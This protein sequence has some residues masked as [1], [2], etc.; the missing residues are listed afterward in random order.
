[1]KIWDAIVVGAGPAGCAAAYDLAVRGREVL[2][3]D[4]ADFPRQKACAGGL[5]IKAV[6]ALRYS[7]EPVVRQKI[8]R[9][10]IEREPDRTTILGRRFTCCLMTVRQEFDDFCFRQT[11][12]VGAQFRRIRSIDTVDQSFTDVTL[13]VDGETLRAKFV[14]GADGV[15]SRIRQLTGMGSSWFWRGFALEAIVPHAGARA[16]DLTFDFAPVRDGYGWVFPKGNHLNIGL[17]S[18]ADNEKI[19]RARL[20]AY[21]RHRVA[22]ADADCIIGQYA[23]FGAAQHS[24][25]P[26]RIFLAGDAGGF[27]DPL[28]G[29]G[30]YFAIASGQ[31]AAV[32]I[33]S[34]LTSGSPAQEEFARATAPLRANLAIATS[35]A[36]WFYRNLDLAY[37]LISIPLLHKTALNTFSNGS[38]LSR[39]ADRVRKMLP[40]AA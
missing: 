3:I 33:E 17:Y 13:S 2:L 29:E 6:K 15:H 39:L 12:D 38:D 8:D 9:I 16:E 40:D 11:V 26:G 27:V 14:V 34:D 20:L 28:T 30:I 23:G 5:T 24:P 10:R 7:I 18:Y 19:D 35:A 36:R 22:T 25:P 32:A 4:K 21:V 1:M 37:R 31:A